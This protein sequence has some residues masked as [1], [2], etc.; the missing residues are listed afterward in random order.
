[1]CATIRGKGYRTQIHGRWGKMHTTYIVPKWDES[2]AETFD[3]HCQ[4]CR[5]LSV[6]HTTFEDATRVAEEHERT[7][8]VPKPRA[9]SRWPQKGPWGRLHPYL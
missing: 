5:F 8:G 7:T 4:D 1:M 9:P 2:H 3:V 6:G